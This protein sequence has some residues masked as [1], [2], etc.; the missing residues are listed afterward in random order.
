M[1]REYELGTIEQLLVTPARPLEMVIG[2]LVPNL[3]LMLLILAITTLAG[4]FWFGVPFRGSAWLYAWLSLLFLASGLGL[5]LLISAMTRTQREAQQS[6]S[7]CRW[8]ACC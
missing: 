2:K 3:L 6:P 8:S 1:V 7:C 5:G 4:V